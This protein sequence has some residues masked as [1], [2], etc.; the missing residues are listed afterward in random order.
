MDRGECIMKVIGI[1][2]SARKDGNTAI[3]I[4]KVFEE[5]E[6]EGFETE[7]IQL[8]G[9]R[10]RGCTACGRCIEKRDGNCSIDDDIVNKI[11]EKMA[12][13]DGIILGSPVY[14]SNISSEM[15]ALIDRAGRVVRAK[16]YMLKR[17]VGAAVVAVRR[18]GA[19][20]AFNA[21]NEFFFVEQMIVPG[22]TYWNLGIGRD[23]G[24]V[25]N[26]EEG[27]NNMKNLGQ[28]MAWLIRKLQ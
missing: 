5:L 28:N 19:L 21:M 22:S 15:K 8:A 13:A 25:E 2:G 16:D 14:F 7:L 23:I 26:D 12:E 27:M 9:E 11:I 3:M 4:R 18:A 20:P 24:D 17:K 6:E 1:N 10:I